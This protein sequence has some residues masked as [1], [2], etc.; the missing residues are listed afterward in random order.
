MNNFE[1]SLKLGELAIRTVNDKNDFL[2]SNGVQE[3]VFSYQELMVM[4]QL[5]DKFEMLLTT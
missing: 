4:R 3:I 2:V 5:I 1:L